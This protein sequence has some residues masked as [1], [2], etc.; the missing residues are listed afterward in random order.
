M[1]N[2]KNGC[3]YGRVNRIYI[4]EIKAD[5]N[6]MG[7]KMSKIWW[8]IVVVG[9]IVLTNSNLAEKIIEKLLGLK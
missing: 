7:K 6:G 3:E 1:A 4:D 8:G 9:L 5:I 2:G